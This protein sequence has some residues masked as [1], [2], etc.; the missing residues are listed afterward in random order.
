MSHIGIDLVNGSHGVPAVHQFSPIDAGG[1]AR[2]D[3]DP[4][5]RS[6]GC[7]IADVIHPAVE[8]SPPIA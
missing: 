8:I 5:R 3:R 1:E 7:P 6:H 4:L 2:G